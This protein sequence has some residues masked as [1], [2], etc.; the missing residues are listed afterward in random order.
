M[1]YKKHMI[2]KKSQDVEPS[3]L[4]IDANK[5]PS[6]DP[7]EATLAEADFPL[8]PQAMEAFLRFLETD[9]IDPAAD[10]SANEPDSLLDEPTNG[11]PGY[12]FL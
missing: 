10:L 2:D 4:K 12:P 8:D 5:L 7:A 6:A 3:E 11:W 1:G 9:L